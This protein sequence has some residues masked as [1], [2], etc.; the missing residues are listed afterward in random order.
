MTGMAACD[1]RLP[2]AELTLGCNVGYRDFVDATFL[3]IALGEGML[4]VVGAGWVTRSSLA[5]APGDLLARADYFHNAS[6]ERLVRVEHG[7]CHLVLRERSL[8]VRVAARDGA[9]AERVLEAIADSLP[10]VDSE[11]REVPVHFWWWQPQVAR[12]L[13]RMLASPAWTEIARNYMAST[14]HQLANLVQWDGGP[15]P[16][17]RLLLWHGDPGTGKTNAIRSLIGEW[18]SWAEFHFVTDPEEFL[19]NPSYLLTVL[20]DGGRSNATA[21]ANRWRVLVLEDAGE[22]LAPDAKHLAGQALSRL[23]NVCDGVLGQAMKALILVTTNEALRTLHPAL[24][25]PGRCLAEVRFDPFG[26][27]EAEQWAKLHAMEL[28]TESSITLADLYAHLEGRSN[29]APDRP[30]FG[31][32]AA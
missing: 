23:L 15:P 7:I 8:T 29:G 22:Y 25:R 18:R 16:G 20:G 6:N 1:R 17:G 5:A 12:E 32:S 24:A 4:T 19:R 27:E 21:P 14:R 11:D 3:R 2:T 31:F 9:S 13:G 30:A 10:E 26:P 28:P